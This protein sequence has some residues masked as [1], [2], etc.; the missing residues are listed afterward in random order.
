MA[1]RTNQFT[2]ASGIGSE[3]LKNGPKRAHAAI[4]RINDLV[5]RLG[6]PFTAEFGEMHV[7]DFAVEGVEILYGP[8]DPCFRIAVLVDDTMFRVTEL[9][10]RL[11][12]FSNIDGSL[13]K[14]VRVIR[15][16]T[17]EREL[18]RANTRLLRALAKVARRGLPLR[19]GLVGYAY[20]E[21][22][23]FAELIPMPKQ[24]H[25]IGLMLEAN[26]TLAVVCDQRQR[27]LD[28]ADPQSL[29]QLQATVAD[30]V[31][32]LDQPRK[33]SGKTQNAR[34]GAQR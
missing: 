24:P 3:G 10:R 2:N 4:R 31:T 14:L 19:V 5:R 34:A 1:A 30:Y 6:E 33:S 9:D 22:A 8:D 20:Q 29:D 25:R 13:G 18:A 26:N 15:Q 21:N 23:S 7:F 12:A 17:D 16:W 32:L 27:V 28:L 11:A